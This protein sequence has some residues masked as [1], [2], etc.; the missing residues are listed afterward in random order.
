MLCYALGTLLRQGLSRVMG[1]RYRLAAV[2][3]A[4]AE[5]R[6]ADS[7]RDKAP[8]TLQHYQQEYGGSLLAVL[9]DPACRP[10]V[11]LHTVGGQQHA[12]LLLDELVGRSAAAAAPAPPAAAALPLPIRLPQPAQQAQQAAGAAPQL[13]NGS[14][15]SAS[16]ATTAAAANGTAAAGAGA[17]SAVSLLPSW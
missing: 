10:Y 5:Q 2:R 11:R 13:G 12:L 4:A 3:V 17:T 8:A 1:S 14:S 9:S 15:S 7:L 6:M 16:A